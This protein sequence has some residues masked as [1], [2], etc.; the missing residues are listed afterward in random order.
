MIN[1]NVCKVR[2]FRDIH[3]YYN[4]NYVAPITITILNNLS[5]RRILR[6]Y[7]FRTVSENSYFKFTAHSNSIR[8]FKDNSGYILNRHERWPFSRFLNNNHKFSS[9][10]RECIPGEYKNFY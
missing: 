5:F 8:P 9:I 3:K 6:R 1:A 10:T 4:G 7:T 2:S